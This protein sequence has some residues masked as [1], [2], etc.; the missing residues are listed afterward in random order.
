MKKRKQHLKYKT[1]FFKYKSNRKQTDLL[2]L[3]SRQLTE[4]TVNI[5]QEHYFSLSLLAKI[6]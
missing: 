3:I 2:N 1:L 4:Q 5:K 6:Y